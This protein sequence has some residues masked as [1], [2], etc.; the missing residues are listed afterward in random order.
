MTDYAYRQHSEALQAQQAAYQL[1]LG[2]KNILYEAD[3]AVHAALEVRAA[4][5]A[6]ES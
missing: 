1:L 6:D 5:Q 3:R 4:S 2:E